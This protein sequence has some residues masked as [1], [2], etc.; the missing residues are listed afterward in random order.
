MF[1]KNHT[2]RIE[3]IL[4]TT[5]NVLEK[6]LIRFLY[7]KCVYTDCYYSSLDD[8]RTDSNS[9]ITFVKQKPP[10]H[11]ID[12]VLDSHEYQSFEHA[13]TDSDNNSTITCT[14]SK[15]IYNNVIFKILSICK[16]FICST[17]NF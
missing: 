5:A 9:Y 15:F 6:Y 2:K 13:N 3:Q 10:Q 7:S 17:G 4:S 8:F 14:M 16:K 12:N 11:G 1:G